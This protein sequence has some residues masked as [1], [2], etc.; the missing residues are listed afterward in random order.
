MVS[1]SVATITTVVQSG[2]T[3]ATASATGKSGGVR[4]EVGVSGLLGMLGV[5]A[6][7]F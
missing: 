4:V 3:S 2:A 1:E 7:G 6:L 5:V